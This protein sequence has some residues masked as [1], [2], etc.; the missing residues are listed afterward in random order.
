MLVGMIGAGE[1]LCDRPERDNEFEARLWRH[2]AFCRG[3]CL[4]SLLKVYYESVWTW[5]TGEF[6][7]KH[8]HENV[9]VKLD[10][11]VADV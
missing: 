7:E 2:G 9:K 11:E 6:Y 3:L 1:I 4:L 5:I 10:F 8:C